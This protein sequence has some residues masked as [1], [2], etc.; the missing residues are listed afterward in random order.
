[1]PASAPRTGDICMD[2]DIPVFSEKP[3]EKIQ[4]WLKSDKTN[5]Y[6]HENP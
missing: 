3:V 4:V 2:S 5:V 6:F 1:M